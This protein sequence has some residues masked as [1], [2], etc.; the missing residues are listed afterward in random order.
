MV[1]PREV[2]CERTF[3]TTYAL[4]RRGQ[5]KAHTLISCVDEIQD[6]SSIIASL[7]PPVDKQVSPHLTDP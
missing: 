2:V 5:E 3:D 1:S 4:T 6:V 7:L